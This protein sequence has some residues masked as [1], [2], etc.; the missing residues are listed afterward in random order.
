MCGSPA[1]RSCRAA[2]RRDLPMPGSPEINTIWP[3]PSLARA[4]RR[5]SSSI[6]ASRP[7]RGVRDAERSAS[8]R[9]STAAGLSTCQT[10]T[11]SSNPLTSAV[12]RSRYSKSSPSSRRVASASI[13]PFAG[14]ISWRRAA[15]FGLLEAGG[16]VRRLADDD[17]A[18]GDADPARQRAGTALQLC[19]ALGKRQARP[20]GALSVVFVSSRIA[21]INQDTVAHIL[22]DIAVELG[23]L[24]GN[25]GVIGAEHLAQILWIE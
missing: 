14:A 4:Q 22:G 12:P 18:G 6:S 15:R 1:S 19:D 23:D 7:T 3:S 13:T 11:G 9:L 10:A 24:L 20:H 25:G 21:E 8:N 5:S 2:A 16:K 17:E